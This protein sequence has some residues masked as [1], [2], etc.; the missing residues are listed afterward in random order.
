MTSPPGSAQSTGDVSRLSNPDFPDPTVAPANVTAVYQTHGDFLWLTLQ[1]LGVRDA[2]RDDALQDVLVVVHHR[3]H[4][5]DGR[6][7]LVA[8]LFGVCVRVAAAQRRRAHVRREQL[9]GSVPEDPATE[10][11]PDPEEALI[12]AQSLARLRAVLDEMDLEKRAVFVMYE[13]DEVPAAEIASVLGIPFNTV[14][15]RLRAA[16]GQF[17]RVAARHRARESGR[18][19]PLLP[20]LWDGDDGAEREAARSRAPS[21][22]ERARHEGRL[23]EVAAARPMP[24]P[25]RGG[26]ALA[27]GAGALVIALAL[28]VGARDPR[29]TG[30]AATTLVTAPPAT[31]TAPSVGPEARA[32]PAVAAPAPPPARPASPPRRPAARPASPPPVPPV[33]APVAVP[34]PTAPG[35]GAGAVNPLDREVALLGRAQALLDRDPAAA[36]AQLD[37]HAAQFPLG[38][39]AAERDYLAV[40]AL[41]RLGRRREAA[42]RADALAARDPRGPFVR[43]VQRLLAEAADAGATNR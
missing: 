12:T 13:I 27:G 10:R 20:L 22:S 28:A 3:L 35:A 2:D 4:T 17:E 43:R 19:A 29:P 1:R 39:M 32:A 8:W 14:H 16:R 41:L 36:L 7:P 31:P 42:T 25:V 37:A 15:S 33:A 21:P 11:P 6:V 26:L 5:F 40:R 34:P 9:W 24:T 38:E 30:A 18:S 23:P